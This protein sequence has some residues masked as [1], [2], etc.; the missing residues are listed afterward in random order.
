VRAGGRQLTFVPLSF[1]FE[2][3]RWTSLELA[4]ALYHRDVKTTVDELTQ[5]IA[6]LPGSPHWAGY[7][8]VQ[9]R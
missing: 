6:N 1:Y 9:K 2:E 3:A 5:A 4:R 7:Y 8:V